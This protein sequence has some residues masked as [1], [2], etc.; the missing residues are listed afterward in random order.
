MAAPLQPNPSPLRFS[1]YE[2]DRAGRQLSKHGVRIR[3]QNQPFEIL[4]MLLERPGQIVSREEMRNRLWPENTFV[5]YE[6]SLN[7]AV[8]K[9]RAALG[10]SS[11]LPRYIE[12]VAGQGYR[13]IAPVTVEPSL[14]PP[15]G[16]E[17]KFSTE[18]AAPQNHRHGTPWVTLSLALVM[19]TGAGAWAWV[20]WHRSTVTAAPHGP[21]ADARADDLYQ[22]GRQFWDR[23]TPAGFEEALKYFGQAVAAN[24]NHARAYAG[25]ADTYALMAGYNG[26][27]IDEYMPKARA[28]ALKAIELNDKL[29]EPHA[30]LAVIAQDYDWDWKTAEEQY[31]RAI[32]LDPNYATA[33]H[34]YAECL[35]LQGR[36]PEAIAEID[37]ARQLNPPSLI[38]AVDRGAI[39]YFARQY[40]PAI[41]QFQAVLRLEFYP[42]A[43][44]VSWA[45]L[46]EG[47]LQEA[48]QEIEL[49]QRVRNEP[50]C[51]AADANVAARAG[52]RR[53]A[54]RMVRKLE[55]LSRPP[56][57][58]PL[59]LAIAWIAIGNKEKA[60]Q[61]L[62]LALR[63]HSPSITALKVDPVYDPLRSDPR[64]DGYLKRLGFNR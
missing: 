2:V 12:T 43:F 48:R 14:V 30:S 16:E 56:Q 9:L 32:E 5:E 31:R 33:H 3:I 61:N 57:S 54:E 51:W 29:A 62:E 41:D 47:R 55:D 8:R 36:F 45:Y 37:R 60:F 42:R 64:F 11:D 52:N 50:W 34:W 20:E 39:F 23:R 63:Q 13:F 28:A 24:P 4:C 27:P 7:T 15:A 38:I 40:G 6:D 53:E 21:A 10:D 58:D 59:P 49:W 46:Q 1:V 22:K 44:M 35:A 19:V 26:M 18:I 17:A 25:I